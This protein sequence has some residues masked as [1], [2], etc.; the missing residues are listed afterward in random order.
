MRR[1][2]TRIGSVVVGLEATPDDILA[3]WEPFLRR[4]AVAAPPHVTIRVREDRE[5]DWPRFAREMEGLQ[6]FGSPGTPRGET[7]RVAGEG[8]ELD[9][10]VPQGALA[11]PRAPG[12]PRLVNILLSAAFNLG[13]RAAGVDEVLLHACGVSDGGAACLFVGPS[14]AGK[15]TLARIAG[16]E[17]LLHDEALVLGRSPDGTIVVQATPLAGDLPGRVPGPLAVGRLIVLEHGTR[18]T[19]S[20]LVPADLVHQL[21]PQVFLT[22]PPFPGDPEKLTDLEERL[23]WA[24]T[25]AERIPGGRLAFRPGPPALELALSH[26]LR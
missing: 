14:G 15:S 17:R 9:V 5:V 19:V 1:L 25:L 20:P 18:D 8:R 6:G 10:R 16:A 11:P 22:S 7:V 2:A 12:Q 3:P 13:R 4:F 21:L 26:P 23:G 24:V